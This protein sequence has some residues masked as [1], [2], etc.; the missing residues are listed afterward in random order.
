M[1]VLKRPSRPPNE[2]PFACGVILVKSV[3]LLLI[4]GNEDSCLELMFIDAPV[5][6]LFNIGLEIPAE[7]TTSLRAIACSE[8]LTSKT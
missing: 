2:L 8:S 5:L 1:I 3:I 6:S 7:T 4:E